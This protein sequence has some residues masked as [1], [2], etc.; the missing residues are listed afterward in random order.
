MNFNL[1]KEF[2]ENPFGRYK[3]DGPYSGEEFRDDYLKSLL[4]ECKKNNE[5]LN[6]YIDDVP[7]GISSSF[8]SESF[9]GLVTKNYFSSDELLNSLLI[10]KSED[11]SYITEIYTY[12]REASA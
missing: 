5:T 7:I 1:A 2:S 4:D 8:L 9:G 3:S 12:I 10:I 11:K 6:I